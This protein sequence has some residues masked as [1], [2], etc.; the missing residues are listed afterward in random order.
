MRLWSIHPQYL[1]AKGLVALWREALLAQAV[2]DN[3][4]RGYRNHPQLT[5]LYNAEQPLLAIANYLHVVANEAKQRQYRFDASKIVNNPDPNLTQIKVTVG[6]L[7]Y[8]WQHLLT[9]L[10]TRDPNRY[11]RLEPI[12]ISPTPH[13][14][15]TVV[16]GPIEP[17]EVVV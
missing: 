1:D 17:W 9:K 4:T 12:A 6:Q 10:R 2:L 3:K 13:P 5:R 14:L 16:P 7:A 8:E 11:A 15:F